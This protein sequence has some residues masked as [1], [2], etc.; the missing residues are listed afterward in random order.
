MLK[1]QDFFFRQKVID[2][3]NANLNSYEHTK[4]SDV[5]FL[6]TK[7]LY[8]SLFA[9]MRLIIVQGGILINIG[10]SDRKKESHTICQV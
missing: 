8:S 7:K 10:E 2:K 5:I 3:A 4:I 6:C 1:D 9:S